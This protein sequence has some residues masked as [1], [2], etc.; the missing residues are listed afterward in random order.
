[1]EKWAGK[2][3]S[4]YKNLE[5]KYGPLGSP[6]APATGPPKGFGG[7]GFGGGRGGGGRAKKAEVADCAEEFMRLVQEATPPQYGP[8]ASTGDESVRVVERKANNSA[9]GLE[10][11]SFTVC[12][13]IRPMLEHE[14]DKGGEHFVAIV[15]GARTGTG[16]GSSANDDGGE[17]TKGEYQE[18]VV[19]LLPKVTIRGRP[20]LEATSHNFDYVFGPESTNEEIFDLIGRPLVKRAMNG[21]VGVCFA[22]G[23]TGSGKTHTMNGFLDGLLAS[24]ELFQAGVNRL[25]FSFI[26]ILGPVINDCLLA[27]EDR[28]QAD[29]GPGGHGAHGPSK[30]P[31]IGETLDGRIMTRNI[32]EVACGT[33]EELGRLVDM[34]KSRRTTAAT[35]RNHESSRS[36]AVAT[37]TVTDAATGIE[38]QLY[39]I[40]LAGS[41][42]SSDSKNHDKARMA[43]TKAIN[44]SL[45]ALKD[46]IRARTMASRPGAGAGAEQHVPYRRSKLTLLMKDVFDVGCKR[47]CST[48]VLAACSPLALDVAHSANTLKYAS[49]LRVAVQRAP[50]NLELD[51]R[52]PALWDHSQIAAWVHATSE[53][54][55][56]GDAF[57]AGMTGVQVCAL[58]EV[59]F[60]RRTEKA[61]TMVATDA[62]DI[63]D[64]AAA[65]PMGDDNNSGAGVSCQARVAKAIYTALWTLIVDAK[66]RRRRPNGTIITA[67]QEEADR[68]ARAA[69]T[70][71]KAAL[72]AE[73]EEHMRSEQ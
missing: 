56:D 1:M 52:D 30:L 21:Q 63:P 72:W 73:R 19:V 69:E 11:S 26:E 58:P 45:M 55:V 27:P 37:I 20:V 24:S 66:T 51:V 53:S 4:L 14:V 41:E 5:K 46:C 60:Y 59:E 40:D 32:S 36:H 10:T 23:Q 25:K 9:N 18:E 57:T 7:K 71:A 15:P 44:Q 70:A 29:R 3:A 2:Y 64:D 67:E 6:I 35:E 33:A 13:R 39:I 62:A 48:V 8:R 43:E 12:T 49:P 54:M 17:E 28:P 68:A 61:M 22:Y 16:A 65:S 38:G 31:Q 34:A 47:L 42:R 50:P